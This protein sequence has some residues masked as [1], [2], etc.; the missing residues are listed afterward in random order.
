MDLDLPM[1]LDFPLE[2]AAPAPL[3]IVLGW[4]RLRPGGGAAEEI[5]AADWFVAPGAVR[6]GVVRCG[7]REKA[8]DEWRYTCFIYIYILE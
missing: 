8:P 6:E 7:V 2:A 5:G 1:Q 4:R 3:L